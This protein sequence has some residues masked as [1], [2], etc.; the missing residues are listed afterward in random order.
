MI[1]ID[2]EKRWLKSGI[3]NKG[4]SGKGTVVARFHFSFVLI[5]QSSAFPYCNT[6]NWYGQS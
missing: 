2:K 1:Y 6:T 3:A 5:G 4:F